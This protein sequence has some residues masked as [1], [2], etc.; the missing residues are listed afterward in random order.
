MY[1]YFLFAC[2]ADVEYRSA[3]NRE[4]DSQSNASIRDVMVILMSGL[5]LINLPCET[6][7]SYCANVVQMPGGIFMKTSIVLE[8]NW[9]RRSHSAWV[10]CGIDTYKAIR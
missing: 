8:P 7:V 5:Y 6:Y 1:Y 4:S 3:R 2:I 9:H 10:Q